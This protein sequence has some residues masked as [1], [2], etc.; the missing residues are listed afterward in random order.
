MK[1]ILGL[2]SG[3]GLFIYGMDL[4]R[5]GFQRSTGDK[6]KE[7]IAM[8]TNNIFLSVLVGT[9]FTIIIQSSSAATI[10]VVGL[11]NAGILG[12]PQAL[13]LIMGANIGTTV[14]PHLIS[15]NLHGI[16]SI[17]LF[18]GVILHIFPTRPKYKYLSEI[19]LG[20]GLLFV[21]MNLM[22][23]SLQPL[24]TLPYFE[25]VILYFSAN[26][27]L[28]L[29]IGVLITGL[30]QSSSASIGLLMAICT[31]GYLPLA[32]ALPI[33][34]GGNIGTCLT[35]LISSTGT[36]KNGK[37]AAVM[38][39]IFNIIG[40]FIFIVFLSVPLEFFVSK[41]SPSNI[42]RQIANAHTLFN[43]INT[44]LLLPFA[45]YIVKFSIKLI[46]DDKDYENPTGN[47]MY[48][49]ERLLQTPPIA[50]SNTI[51]EVLRMGDKTSSALDYSFEAILY[52]DLSKVDKSLYYKNNIDKLQTEIQNYLILLSKTSLSESNRSKNSSL[53]NII[54]D[55][56][57][58][59]NYA[60]NIANV[61][62]NAMT[63]NINFSNIDTGE[64]IEIYKKTLFTFNSSL[65]ALENNDTALANKVIKV[66]KEV[67]LLENYF[68]KSYMNTLNSG[69]VNMEIGILYLSL[70]SSLER[71]SNHSARI[72]QQVIST[73]V[74]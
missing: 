52:N 1:I 44:I 30:V 28:G 27:L 35:S 17:V 5:R 12:L 64:L 3:F 50:L 51:S 72:A 65:I 40:A 69:D 23:H 56:E 38:H 36:C 71:I 14:T 4:M 20:I 68:R 24:I 49:D 45:S 31:N 43:I 32:S 53:F 63:S 46:P 16:D 15:F 48:L 2:M 58:I 37:R 26:P 59:S 21:G 7:I 8:L 19:F 54:K 34:Y 22:N 29:L 13:G 47:T 70:L 57:I 9:L 6:L 10:T 18:I 74:N 60:E 39:L 42:S 25:K 33:L 41:I 66:K 73:R 55:I 62:G 11:V 67:S 61:A